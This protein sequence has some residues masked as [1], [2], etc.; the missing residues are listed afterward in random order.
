MHAAC[1]AAVYRKQVRL[2]GTINESAL[3]PHSLPCRSDI[4]ALYFLKRI[5]PYNPQPKRDKR[6]RSAL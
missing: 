1:S 6:S 4:K 2:A 3:V 5:C